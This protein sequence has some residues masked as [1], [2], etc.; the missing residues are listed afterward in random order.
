MVNFTITP[1]T[2]C[3]DLKADIAKRLSFPENDLTL[4]YGLKKIE[5]DC[6]ISTLNVP[7]SS[8][9]TIHQ[10]ESFDAPFIQEQKTKIYPRAPEKM[11]SYEDLHFKNKSDGNKFLFGPERKLE[12]VVFVAGDPYDFQIMVNDLIDMGFE[13]NKVISALRKYKYNKPITVEYLL[14]GKEPQM[15]P[16]EI[17]YNV[18]GLSRYNFRDFAGILDDMT[19]H[20]KHDLLR[21]LEAFPG[22]EPSETL[23]LFV[24]CDFIYEAAEHNIH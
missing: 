17:V 5:N 19:N 1:D 10:N 13:K 4:F 12:P 7:K 14:S 8:F 23:Q 18:D 15:G 11:K 24:A 22:Q 16:R 3:S 20:Q 21:L 2:K 6:V 9:I